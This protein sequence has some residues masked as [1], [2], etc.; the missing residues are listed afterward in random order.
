MLYWSLVFLQDVGLP[1]KGEVI[2]QESRDRSPH[3][4]PEFRSSKHRC[5]QRLP[6]FLDNFRLQSFFQ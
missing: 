5:Q 6:K 4:I 2:A 3:W 1:L